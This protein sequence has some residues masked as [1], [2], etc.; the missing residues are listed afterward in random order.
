[1]KK[2]IVLLLGL[3]LVACGGAVTSPTPEA[4]PLTPELTPD[5]EEIPP[6]TAAWLQGNAVPFNTAQPGVDLS[7]PMALKGIIGNARIVALGEATHGTHEFFQ[8][9]HR[10]LEFLVEEMDFTVFAIEAYWAEATL[11][12]DYVHTGEGNVAELLANLGY[13]PWQ[14]QEVFDLIE[15]M[16]AYNQ[17]PDHAPVSFYG[18]DM[19]NAKGAID[20]LI[21]YL[22]T[23]DPD[24]A[25]STQ[26]RLACFSRYQEYNYQQTE[27]AQQPAATKQECRQD[28]QVVFD[29]LVTHQTAYEAVSSPT[30]FAIAL[31]DARVIQQAEEMAAVAESFTDFPRDWFNARDEAMAENVKW[32]LDYTGSETKIVL[33][34]HNVH[35]QAVDWEFRGTRYLPMGTHLRRE[36]GDKLVVFGF[37]SYG[38]AFNALDYDTATD[39][40][41]GLTAHQAGPSVP[42]S[43]EQYLHSAELPRFF[44]DLRRITAD[45][46]AGSWLLRPHWLHFVGA[47]YDRQ[48]RPEDN[49]YVVVLPEAFDVLVYFDETT[50]SALLR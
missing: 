39:S 12:N 24:S 32:L 45:S 15:W 10:L 6:Q 47:T 22:T 37:S 33:W 13:W 41:A 19:Q 20:Q 7:D 9:K 1:M 40:Y 36:Y 3:H 30:A 11:I 25:V 31:Q 17:I 8:M 5:G 26:A 29:E 21:A 38:G 42:N 43:Y 35:V 34:A 23:V 4:L 49:A 48:S 16:R 50:P 27:Y 44:L 14:T 2:I 18:F 28:L 46:P